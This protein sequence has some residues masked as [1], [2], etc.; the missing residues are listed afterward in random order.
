MTYNVLGGTL[1][2]AQSVNQFGNFS[3]F[4]CSWRCSERISIHLY[5]CWKKL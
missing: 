4:H 2:L 1:N 3:I 5:C